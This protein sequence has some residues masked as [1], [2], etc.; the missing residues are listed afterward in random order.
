MFNKLKHSY[1]RIGAVALAAAALPGCMAATTGT[2]GEMLAQSA[3]IPQ[4]A[5]FLPAEADV[6]PGAATEVDG[7]WKINEIG[8]RVRIDRGRAIVVDGWLHALTLKVQPNMVVAKDFHSTGPRSFEA[9]D[10]PNMGKATY[11]WDGASAMQ[12][13]IAGVAGPINLT[14]SRQSGGAYAGNAGGDLSQCENLGVDPVS[15]DVACMD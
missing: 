11:T 12:V 2:A 1:G 7:I 3:G 10:L 5:A 8:K 4:M 6:P 14:L 9:Y 13:Q 15:G